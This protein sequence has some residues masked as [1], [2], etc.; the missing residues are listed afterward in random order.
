MN[1]I[2]TDG[3]LAENQP[4]PTRLQLFATWKQAEKKPDQRQTYKAGCYLLETLTDE[5]AV[6]AW[7][8]GDAREF[9]Q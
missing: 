5:S 3:P 7:K 2:F 1:L 9:E 6:Y 4:P 8:I